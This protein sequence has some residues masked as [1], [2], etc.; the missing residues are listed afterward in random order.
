[1]HFGIDFYNG[2]DAF[3]AMPLVGYQKVGQFMMNAPAHLAAEPPYSENN[4]VSFTVYV[5]SLP[6]ANHVKLSATTRA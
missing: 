6:A 2:F 4:F 3:T 1:M 5:F